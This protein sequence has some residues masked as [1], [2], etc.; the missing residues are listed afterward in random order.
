MVQALRS[1]VAWRVTSGVAA[2]LAGL[3][4]RRLVLLAWPSDDRA[5]DEDPRRS[6]PQALGWAVAL[7]VA[8]GV[9]RVVAV[10]G[11]ARVWEGATGE[12]PPE[13]D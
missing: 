1:R 12:R 8:V 5:P 4:A 10:R 9:A 6:W 11:A 3:G 13:R 2:A 7:G